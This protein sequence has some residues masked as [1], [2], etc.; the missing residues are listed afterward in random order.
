MKRQ[1]VLPC[2]GCPEIFPRVPRHRRSSRKTFCVVFAQPLSVVN[3]AAVKFK[4]VKLVAEG[5]SQ[6]YH[7]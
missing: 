7:Q 2:D 4:K 6:G 5:N 3:I 1:P